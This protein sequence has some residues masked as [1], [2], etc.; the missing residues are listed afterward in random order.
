V[1]RCT[2][3]ALPFL[4]LFFIGILETRVSIAAGYGLDDRVIEVR[5]PVGS[6]IFTS[7]RRPD[8]LWG[9]PTSYAMGTGVKRP[10]SGSDY[11]PPT[12]IEAEKTWSIY[13]LPHTPSWRSVSLVTQKDSYPSNPCILLGPSVL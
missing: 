6:R 12:I 1:A 5:V 9:P 2:L 11:T 7:P 8:R 13:P 10:R 4:F 3:I